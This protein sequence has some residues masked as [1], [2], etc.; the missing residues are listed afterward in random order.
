MKGHRDCRT[1]RY[2]PPDRCSCHA[3]IPIKP[4]TRIKPPG[5]VTTMM[6]KLYRALLRSRKPARTEST[7]F[8]G[9][10]LDR[11]RDDVFIALQQAGL[12]R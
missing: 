7:R 12:G 2:C 9:Q 10:L 5:E 4:A 11:K 3:A 8:N 6:N 1:P